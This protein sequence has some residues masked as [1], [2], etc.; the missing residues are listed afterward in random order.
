LVY[1]IKIESNWF[2]SG[3]LV[4]NER[5]VIT[6][7]RENRRFEANTLREL[8]ERN[9]KSV[10]P[11]TT[12]AKELI[13]ACQRQLAGNSPPANPGTREIEPT[14]RARL[15]RSP[16]PNSTGSGVAVST[17]SILTNAHVVSECKSIA[18][19]QGSDSWPVETIAIDARIDLALLATQKPLLVQAK[20]RSSALLGEDVMVAGYPLAGLL[21]SDLIVTGGQ[22]NSLAGLRNDPTLLQI[23]AP[24]Q[25]GN[26]GGPLLDRYGSVVG[27]V[28]SKLN[29]SRLEK[30]TGDIAQNV[31][32]AIKPELVRLFLD[33]NSVKYSSSQSN[34]RLDGADLAQIARAF[35]YQVLCFN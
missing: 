1:R 11:D 32:F 18:V 31:N 2:N 22:V 6:D 25:P 10:F 26:S 28:V 27:I 20:L 13:I 5:F 35:T 33:V 23:S 19:R 8:S 12:A 15:E 30:I 4:V 21:G 14:P 17:K 9:F 7:C 24:V 3:R 16:T 29:V 34:S